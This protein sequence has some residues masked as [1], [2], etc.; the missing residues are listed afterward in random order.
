MREIL[1]KAKERGGDW[2]YGDLIRENDNRFGG[3][4]FYIFVDTDDVEDEGEKVRIDWETIG[5]FIGL[6]DIKNKKVFE[7]DILLYKGAKGVVKYDNLNAMFVL[8]IPYM[9][10]I[11][12]FDS[13]EMNFEIIGNI[14]DNPE[15]L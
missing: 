15:L 11:Y 1:F 7:G 14:H 8:E 9:R 10:S 4:F 13:M 2:V 6:I 3:Q 5:E 12:S